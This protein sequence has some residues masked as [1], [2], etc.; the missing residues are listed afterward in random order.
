MIALLNFAAIFLLSLLPGEKTGNDPHGLHD[1]AR[2]PVIRKM[3]VEGRFEE[4]NAAVDGF[5][6]RKLSYDIALPGR[7]EVAPNAVR[8]A[9]RGR[10]DLSAL[11]DMVKGAIA[12]ASLVTELKALGPAKGMLAAV[13]WVSSGMIRRSGLKAPHFPSYFGII[14]QPDRRE[15]DADDYEALEQDLSGAQSQMDSSYEEIQGRLS[16]I[17]I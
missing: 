3:I 6:G 11:L 9:I 8:A 13:K 4:F 14:A 5:M 16:E 2:D 10:A 17:F 15:L 1:L 12:V 7:P